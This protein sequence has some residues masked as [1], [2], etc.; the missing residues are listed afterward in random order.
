M[1]KILLLLFSALTI[2]AMAQPIKNRIG[3]NDIVNPRPKQTRIH[4]G[5]G[6]MS[7]GQIAPMRDVPMQTPVTYLHAGLL[8]GKSGIGQH[9]HHTMEEMYVLLEGEAEFTINGRTAVIKAPAMVPCKL[10]DAHGLYNPSDKTLRWL[11]FGV[12]MRKGASDAFNLG[13]DRVGVVLD[14]TPSFVFG[15]LDK[16]LLR[17]NPAP[18]TANAT[19]AG[20]AVAA[21]PQRGGRPG[22]G[23]GFGGPPAYV[24]EGVK[25]RRVLGPEIFKTQWDHVDHVIIPAGKSATRQIDGM[26]EIFYVVSGNGSV[27]NAEDKGD[28]KQDNSF[29][30]KVNEKLTFAAGDKDLEMI[31]VGISTTP[32]TLTLPAGIAMNSGVGQ[33]QGAPAGQGGLRTPTPGMGV[34]IGSEIAATPRATA[35]QMDFIVPKDK[36]EAFE[37][38][39][40]EIYV[41]AMKKQQGYVESRLLRLYPADVE[42][43]I[44]GEAT[45][46]NY[47]IQISFLTEA[48]RKKWTQSK[49]HPI[50]WGAA[51]ALGATY[52][53]RGYDVMGADNNR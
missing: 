25:Y 48:D 41:P 52:K 9:F 24:G 23:R 19:P 14:K 6:S 51:T 2:S 11:N 36:A 20:A 53:W 49:E 13:D 44:E 8:Y 31:V 43:S 27:A 10:G 35:L 21:A 45:T 40:S 5:A 16:S 15:R 50:A 4:E 39:Y 7:F 22:F 33:G 42:K 37:K 18:V 38:M 34:G 28:L 3:L 47:Q 30:S 12:A 1:K 32:K 29:Y 26:E 17:E 46:Y